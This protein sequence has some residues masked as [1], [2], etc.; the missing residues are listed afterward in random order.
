MTMSNEEF[1]RQAAITTAEIQAAGKLNPEQSERFIDYV[2]DESVLKNLGR[3]VKFRNEQKDI[4]K[5]GVGNRV[6][7]RKREATDPMVRRLVS[8]SKITLQPVDIMTPWEV[9]DR[10]RRHNIEG[11]SVEDTII[12]MMA[13]QKANNVDEVWIGGM[14]PMPARV[15][16]EIFDNASTTKFVGD[17]YLSMFEGMIKQAEGG[18]VFDAENASISDEIFN[19]AI[20]QMPNKFRR[21]RNLLRYM[22]SPDHE[23]SYRK[24]NSGRMTP[25]GDATLMTTK[26]LT[27]FGIEMEQIPLLERNPLYA[28]N[29]DAVHDTPVSFGDKPVTDF[30]VTPNVL[31]IEPGAGIDDYVLGVDYTVDLTAGTWTAL[32]TGSITN[33]ETVRLTYRVGGRM[34]L[35]NPDNIIL[36]LGLDVTIE[37]ARNIFRT[38]DEY[39]ISMA[40]DIKFEN[41]DAVV[42]V[43]NLADPTL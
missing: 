40:I 22:I 20:L 37:K 13:T 9:S 6:A 33:G 14:Q 2:I 3:M 8:H 24:Y 32:S 15:E 16:N 4:D 5:I 26:N 12:R 18:N 10:Y 35:T 23:Q 42:L 31:P 43:K 39:A 41:L 36:A 25:D 30:V 29:S 21:N 1:A 28:V 7:V 11:D 17:D 38:V 27:P 19:Q 34:I